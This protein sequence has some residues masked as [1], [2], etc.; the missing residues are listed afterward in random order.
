MYEG[1]R[2]GSQDLNSFLSPI[3]DDIKQLQKGIVVFDKYREEAFSYKAHLV[4]LL[5]DMPAISKLM[6]AKGLNSRRPCR[7]CLIYPQRGQNGKYYCAH[8]PPVNT[9]SY[10]RIHGEKYKAG[11]LPTREH[12]DWVNNALRIEN[13][14]PFLSDSQGINGFSPFLELSSVSVPYSFCLDTMHVV[15]ENLVKFLWKVSVG[16]HDEA[17]IQDGLVGSDELKKL[18]LE[19]DVCN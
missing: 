7:C 18:Q 15:L 14:E 9:P 2:K 10:K 4:F 5:G 11:Q 3:I 13:G 6:N 1:A 16:D 19:F 12:E 17:L 8:L